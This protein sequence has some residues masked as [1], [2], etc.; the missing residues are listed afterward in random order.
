MFRALY[1][2]ACQYKSSV[3]APSVTGIKAPE[4]KI[5]GFK[6]AIAIAQRLAFR[7]LQ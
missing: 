2:L 1:L 6:S 5:T 3:D 7:L 4:A